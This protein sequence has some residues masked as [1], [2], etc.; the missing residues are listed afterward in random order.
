VIDEAVGPTEVWVIGTTAVVV[1][2]TIGCCCDL[3]HPAVIVEDVD[4]TATAAI[5][6]ASGDMLGAGVADLVK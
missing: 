2:K 6:I 5:E 3:D 4:A 1:G